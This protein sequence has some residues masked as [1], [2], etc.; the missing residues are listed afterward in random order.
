MSELESPSRR[1]WR[2]IIQRQRASGM[3]VTE[4]CRRHG[5][6]ASSFFGWK[7]KL[8]SF[9]AAGVFVEAKIA[10]ALP[11]ASAVSVMEIRLRHG[12]RVLVGRG[13]DRDLLAEVIAVL[14]GLS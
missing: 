13:F 6:A 10:P 2:E 3:S 7:R 14:E 9:P 1:K 5:V 11:A 8:G 4:F 12:R